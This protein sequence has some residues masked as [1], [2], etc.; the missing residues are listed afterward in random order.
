M[1]NFRN[2]LA[3]ALSL[4]MFGMAHTSAE[5]A[6]S[7]FATGG[8]LTKADGVTPITNGTIAFYADRDNDGLGNF[9]SPDTFASDD[10]DDIFLGI[11]GVGNSD[12]QDIP[13]T[14]TSTFGPFTAEAGD[15]IGIVF[16]DN[17]FSESA[18]GPGFGVDF[19][20]I[21]N[22]ITLE[23][24]NGSGIGFNVVSSEFVPG[25]PSPADV[26]ATDGTTV[27]EPGTATAM[28]ATLGGLVMMSRRRRSA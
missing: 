12:V 1:K 5:A 16:Y 3:V 14:F 13:G 18:T 10:A 19:G 2:T 11:G 17:T 21:E 6:F 20:V 8:P 23:S 15:Q 28:I 7:L 26:S 9:V 4:S 25:N 24:P 22:V 27:P